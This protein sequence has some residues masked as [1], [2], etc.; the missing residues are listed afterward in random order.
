MLA[1][2]SLLIED[3]PQQFSSLPVLHVQTHILNADVQLVARVHRL[4][5]D[6]FQRNQLPKRPFNLAAQVLPILIP[7]GVVLRLVPHI[8]GEEFNE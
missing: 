1:V 3:H 5:D 8:L 7:D 4:H 2:V 6:S